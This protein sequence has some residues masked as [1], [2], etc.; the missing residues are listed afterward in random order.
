ME[1][2]H[3]R[4]MPSLQVL[5]PL[6]LA[7]PLAPL[8]GH[9]QV[10]YIRFVIED[11]I[12][13]WVSEKA[14]FCCSLFVVLCSFPPLTYSKPHCSMRFHQTCVCVFIRLFVCVCARAAAI[15]FFPR[16]EVLLSANHA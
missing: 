15:L 2:R 14:F 1:R 16:G 11:L 13:L 8:P 4:N 10:R 9:H 6:V 12:P 3:D 5:A 7:A